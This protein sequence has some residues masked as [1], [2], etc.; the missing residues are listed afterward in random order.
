[1]PSNLLVSD[2]LI[3]QTWLELCVGSFFC[4]MIYSLCISVLFLANLLAGKCNLAMRGRGM[5]NFWSNPLTQTY[6]AKH[7]IIEL[8]SS[9][10]SGSVIVFVASIWTYPSR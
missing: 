1:M 9:I 10:V 7:I 5:R 6:P 3:K 8:P 2:L 4:I